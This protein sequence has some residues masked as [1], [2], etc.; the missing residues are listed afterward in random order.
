MNTTINTQ[1]TVRVALAVLGLV[2]LTAGAHAAEP[3]I[4]VNTRAVRFA[5]L[6]LNTDA[7]AK[8]LLRRIRMAAE[9]VCGD[10]HTRQMEIA[11]AVHACMNDAIAGGVRQVNNLQLTRVAQKQGYAVPVNVA[12]ATR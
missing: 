3:T 8:V 9:Q 12:V 4:E 7:G 1:N 5:D 10:P 11:Q 2:V 6:N